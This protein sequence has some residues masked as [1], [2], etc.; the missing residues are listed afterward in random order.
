MRFLPAVFIMVAATLS[1]QSAEPDLTLARECNQAWALAGEHR[2]TEAISM[3][4]GVL[5]RDRTFAP[6]YGPLLEA[7]RDT[8]RWDIAEQYFLGLLQQ[9]P[10]NGLIHLALGDTY[11]GRKNYIK[12]RAQYLTWIRLLPQCRECSDFYGLSADARQSL[13]NAAGELELLLARNPGSQALYSALAEAYRILLRRRDA[14]RVYKAGL[15]VAE[16]AGVGRGLAEYLLYGHWLVTA[17]GQDWAAVGT[18]IAWPRFLKMSVRIR[19]GVSY[20]N[21]IFAYNGAGVGASALTRSLGRKP[22]M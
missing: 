12:A 11:G 20:E 17:S 7:F 1:A 8:D 3:L 16:A 5:A 15:P 19:S 22:R 2:W 21:T 10:N 9:D 6:A 4:Q 13:A 18:A 14:L